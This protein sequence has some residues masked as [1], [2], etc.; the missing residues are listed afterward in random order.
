MT[1]EDMGLVIGYWL[2]VI[3]Y[4]LL[5]ISYRLLVTKLGVWSPKSQ[6]NENRGQLLVIGY[7]QSYSSPTAASAR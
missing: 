5:V 3:S 2:L 4:L 1:M 7:A 6:L